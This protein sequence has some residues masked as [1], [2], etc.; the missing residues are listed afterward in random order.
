[1]PNLRVEDSDE[2]QDTKN[3]SDTE[4]DPAGNHQAEVRLVVTIIIE[5]EVS[6]KNKRRKYR[7][8]EDKGLNGKEKE[9]TA[10]F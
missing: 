10:S 6:I 1:M 8:A 9:K 2:A 3:D 5:N 7:D 4:D